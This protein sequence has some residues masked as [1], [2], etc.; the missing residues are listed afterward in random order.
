MQLH[1]Y[2]LAKYQ[3][4]IRTILDAEYDVHTLA[5]YLT[6]P[7]I[8]S[9]F[10]IIRH[11]VDR[12]VPTA[13]A[14]A[15]LEADH[16]IRSTYYLR[17]STFSPDFASRL[18]EL[19]HEVGYHYEDFHITKGDIHAAHRH[20]KHSLEQFREIVPVKTICSH[21]NL[22]RYHNLDMWRSSQYEVSDY[23]LLGE[24]Y[25]TPEID[26]SDPQKLNYFSDTGRRWGTTIPGYGSV[27]STADLIAMFN[28]QVVENAY[29]LVHPGRWSRSR[30]EWT[31]QV[32]WDGTAEFGKHLFSMWT[33]LREKYAVGK[34]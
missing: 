20:F 34:K 26:S 22:S 7:S 19:G 4:L 30:W 12:N 17:R 15:E 18:S 27:T 13:H 33:R 25:L 24:A 31:R 11:D 16:N 8:S 29:L 9:P 21:G 5:S 23:D 6:A 32:V 14:M 10:V 3:D 28:R 2:T 1:G